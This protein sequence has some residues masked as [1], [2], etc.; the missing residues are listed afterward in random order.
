M[1]EPK[2]TGD[3]PEPLFAYLI[4]KQRPRERVLNRTLSPRFLSAQLWETEWDHK[5]A[6]R[7][8]VGN[9]GEEPIP[10]DIVHLR[11]INWRSTEY[12]NQSALGIS[13]EIYPEVGV[14]GLLPQTHNMSS[15]MLEFQFEKIIDRSPGPSFTSD[16][17]ST[18]VCPRS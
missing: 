9:Q 6:K 3:L 11:N 17:R 4:Q 13:D 12:C 7:V 16:P 18:G 10:N 14:E 8:V 5:H 1:K 15:I 2:Q